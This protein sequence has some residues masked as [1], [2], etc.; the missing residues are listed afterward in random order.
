LAS[1]AWWGRWIAA[2]GQSLT[3]WGENLKPALA[4]ITG[5][6]YTQFD[7]H[8]PALRYYAPNGPSWDI[9]S[10]RPNTSLL[11][12]VK[13]KCNIPDGGQAW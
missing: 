10:K 1:T 8:C 4:A 12:E 13:Y 7:C 11:N 6:T 3:A 2:T 9:D 5:G